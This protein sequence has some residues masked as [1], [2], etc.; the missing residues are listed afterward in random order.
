MSTQGPPRR[1]FV[2]GATWLDFV[3]TTIAPR[4]ELIDL[5]PDFE[6]LVAWLVAAGAM[7]QADAETGLARWAGTREASRAVDFAHTLRRQLR[8]L[9]RIADDGGKMDP[10]LADSL[11]RA[12]RSRPGYMELVGNESQGFERVF[13]APPR[14]PF[15][16]LARVADSAMDFL[17][18]S[19]RRTVRRCENPVCLNY[20]EDVSKNRSRR[21]CSMSL[22]GNRAK[23]AA[24]YRRRRAEPGA[25]TPPEAVRTA[26]KPS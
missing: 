10:R 7:S 19:D 21:W 15:A 9:A 17:V 22:C 16:L 3:N 13:R 12:S 26:G 8:G 24:Y 6:S 14:S 4:G 2:A 20:F 25:A 5:V 18:D 11:N 1:F 23:A